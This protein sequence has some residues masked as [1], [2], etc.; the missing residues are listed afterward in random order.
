M[1]GSQMRKR[2]LVEINEDVNIKGNSSIRIDSD[3]EDE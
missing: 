3:N 2:T 1:L